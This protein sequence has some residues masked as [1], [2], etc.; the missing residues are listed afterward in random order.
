LV[1]S[2]EAIL[3]VCEDPRVDIVP[4]SAGG[5]SRAKLVLGEQ[6]PV[7]DFLRELLSYVDSESGAVATYFGVVKGYVDGGRVEKLV[8]EYHEKFTEEALNRIAKEVESK[9]KLKA[10]LIYHSV[11]EFKPGTVVFAA[12]VVGRGRRE[13]VEALREI[14]ERVKHESAIWKKELRDD[15]VFWVLGDGTRLQLKA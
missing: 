13:V 14:V 8:Y 2:R 3:N 7:A 6:V 5:V 11:G 12:G 15:G 1:G 9:A 4:P 10:V